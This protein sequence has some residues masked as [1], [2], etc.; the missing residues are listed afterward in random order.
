MARKKKQNSDMPIEPVKIVKDDL[1][2]PSELAKSIEAVR[3]TIMLSKSSVDYFKK[4]AH[5]YHIKY[6]RMM[7]EVL[8]SYVSKHLYEPIE[9]V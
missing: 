9:K 7:R 4:T 5:K 3:I 6:Q 8:D 1:P 2:S